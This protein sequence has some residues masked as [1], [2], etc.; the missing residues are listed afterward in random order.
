MGLGWATGLPGTLSLIDFP[1]LSVPIQEAAAAPLDET[2]VT[3]L[4][5]STRFS[6]ASGSDNDARDGMRVT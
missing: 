6:Q 4:Q 1:M 5:S 2:P 3:Y